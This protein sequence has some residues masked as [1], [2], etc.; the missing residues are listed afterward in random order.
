MSGIRT[1]VEITQLRKFESQNPDFS[2][3]VYALNDRKIA[4]VTVNLTCFLSTIRKSGT[5]NTIPTCFL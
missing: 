1:P 5:A 2:V 3:N 4:T